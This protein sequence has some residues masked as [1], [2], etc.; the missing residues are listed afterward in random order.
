MAV[1]SKTTGSIGLFTPAGAHIDTLTTS[2]LSASK[3]SAVSALTFASQSLTICSGSDDRTLRIWDCKKRETSKVVFPSCSHGADDR[4]DQVLHGH[5]S[6]ITCCSFNDRDDFV[7]SGSR[8]GDVVVHTISSS[9]TPH[10]IRTGQGAGDAILAA[11]FS[12]FRC[13]AVG[14]LPA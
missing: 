13:A 14:L 3:P 12:P 4:M 9:T 10:W 8:V 6:E 11:Q 1:G 7:A 5:R 2:N